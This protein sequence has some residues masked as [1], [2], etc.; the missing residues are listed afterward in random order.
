MVIQ[1]R[2]HPKNT[3]VVESLH[4]GID[5]LEGGAVWT[6]IMERTDVTLHDVTAPT[7][8]SSLVYKQIVFQR[9]ERKREN[10]LDR[11]F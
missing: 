8:T 7:H 6:F 4:S 11:M 2:T 9:T 3:S 1:N 10:F 5:S